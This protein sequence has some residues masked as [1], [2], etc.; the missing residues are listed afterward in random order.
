VREN[1]VVGPSRGMATSPASIGVAGK[2]AARWRG[3]EE[4]G[5]CGGR[6]KLWWFEGERRRGCWKKK[7]YFFL[8]RF[9][10]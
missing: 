10:H 3:E 7:L 8:I 5:A 1:E 6:S 9:T 4:M 2:L